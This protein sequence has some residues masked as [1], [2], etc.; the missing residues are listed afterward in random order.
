MSVFSLETVKSLVEQIC[1]ALT[2]AI[3][4]G[5]LK[6]GQPLTEQSLQK[7]FGVSRTPIRE[8]LRI[9]E[10][11]GLVTVIPRKGAWVKQIEKKDI[12]ET[13]PIRALL[14]GYAAKV[15]VERMTPDD[16]DRMRRHLDEMER[17][18]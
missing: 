3:I 4:E 18:A 12:E 13:F 8:A 6:P 2:N 17:S 5:R 10:A 7:E 15:A 11:K 16:L 1:E 9:L 14:E